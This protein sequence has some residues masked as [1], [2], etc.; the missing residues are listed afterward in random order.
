MGELCEGEESDF[1][2]AV[3]MSVGVRMEEG[4]V[5]VFAAVVLEAGMREA[6]SDAGRI[7]P[8]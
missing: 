8:A 3:A 7:S 1:E 5:E 6:G 4:V 2:L